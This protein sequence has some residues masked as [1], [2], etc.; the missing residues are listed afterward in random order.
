MTFGDILLA[1]VLGAVLIYSGRN[2]IGGVRTGRMALPGGTVQD[3]TRHPGKFWQA[4]AFE[5]AIFLIL[6]FMLVRQLS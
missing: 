5:G 3:R 2:L 6:G 4:V 1:L